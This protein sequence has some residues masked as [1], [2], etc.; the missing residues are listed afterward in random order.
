MSLQPNAS[1][2]PDRPDD[3]A[4]GAAALRD[5]RLGDAVSA[6]DRALE[7]LSAEGHP[8]QRGTALLARGLA[9]QLLG[10]HSAATADVLG[11]LNVW[12][13]ARAEWASSA[14]SD[15]A[16][17]L[18][19]AN[20]GAADSYWQAALRL[21]ER[22]GDV[23]LQAAVAGEWGRHAA[24]AGDAVTAVAL[25]EKSAEL[26]RRAGDDSIVAKALVNLARVELDA[27]RG[28][29]AMR[30]I[31]E[32]L[33]RDQRG[34]LRGAT[35]G[36]LIDVAAE[37]FHNGDTAHAELCLEQAL[38]LSGNADRQ[39]RERTLAAL[40]GLARSRN[41]L[42]ASARYGEELLESARHSN[43]LTLVA[44]TLHDLGRIAMHAGAD[45]DAASRLTESVVISRSLGLDPL[46]ASGS[47]A[48]AE[49]AMRRGALLRAL[50]YAE[51]AVSLS[52][53]QDDLE[54]C[55]VTLLLVGAEAGRA[56]L[57][58][59]ARPANEGAAE[60]Y[61]LLERDDLAEVVAPGTAPPSKT[62][63]DRTTASTTRLEAGLEA[64]RS[65]VN[66]TGA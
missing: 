11:A 34:E 15:L 48:L 47:R 28:G 30:N 29:H 36:L 32:A 64:A 58:D 49:I 40:S 3:L 25:L 19:G 17:A 61:R 59:V 65:V 14:M 37:A 53:G 43:D 63:P 66:P 21:A 12:S 22:S 39:I 13:L 18:S 4:A 33:A 1:V 35:A 44:E 57:E 6:Y 10:D 27:G 52:M 16:T 2:L 24:R 9:H 7:R 51:Q 50:G 8:E 55:A 26:G 56:G 46:A 41:D 60:I 38:S 31:G 5:G 62:A 23:V 42:V 20:N 54:A 45:D